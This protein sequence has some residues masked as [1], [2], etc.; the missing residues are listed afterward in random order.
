VSKDRKEYR[1]CDYDLGEVARAKTTEMLISRSFA[2]HVALCLK[3][4][5]NL[6]GKNP[7]TVAYIRK[8]L[9]EF[10]VATKIPF[11]RTVR[12]VMKNV[13]AY[14]NAFLAF[15]R[16]P[17]QS[18][19]KARNKFG[20]WLEPIAGIF[21]ASPSSM[22][23]QRNRWGVVT[24][25]H[26]EIEGDTEYDYLEKFF[27][28]EDI[29]HIAYD[30]EDGFAWGTPFVIPTL[31]D[32]RLLRNI[33]ELAHLVVHK[34]T[35]PIIHW[36]VG[37]K[38]KPAMQ[39]D[40]ESSEVTRAEEDIIGKDTEGVFVTS[41]RHQIEVKDIKPQDVT[42][43]L[44]YFQN[45]VMTG[46]NLSTVDMGTGETANRST[47]GEMVKGLQFQCKDF[48]DSVEESFTL[49]F[50]EL[51]EEGGF[52]ISEENR[53]L[54]LFPEI[55]TEEQRAVENHNMAMYQ[56][57]LIDEDE[58][59]IAIGREPISEEQRNRLYFELI[60]KPRIELTAK[61]KADAAVNLTTNKNMPTNQS[62]TKASKG[63]TKNDIF[64]YRIDE[65]FKNIKALFSVNIPSLPD[66][67]DRV[68]RLLF[69]CVPD[70]F[71]PEEFQKMHDACI[72]F[73]F[74]TESNLDWVFSSVRKN[75]LEVLK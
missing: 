51:L 13:V 3:E 20:R 37:Y 17:L 44:K 35:F 40:D 34:G 15:R 71:S 31:D 47:A 6:V 62:G 25:Y 68:Y 38:E 61:S 36:Q 75:L 59:R 67:A 2:K 50:D 45:R 5:W 14:A 12:N 19:G 23:I 49:L 39:F 16:D 53:V 56:A 30:V 48:Q 63:R 73:D 70:M 4:G 66:K 10:E 9:L 42:K 24:G 8:R 52:L 74:V 58:A 54:F 55:D 57:N 21:L 65:L 46:L 1:P 72:L 28:P 11:S 26:Q 27:K 32:V 41:E 33:E 18:S 29:M 22:Q 43:Y 69:D 64:E 7:N 60:E